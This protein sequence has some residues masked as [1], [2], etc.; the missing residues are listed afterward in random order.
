MLEHPDQINAMTRAIIREIVVAMGL[1]PE[2]VQSSL[3]LSL[4]RSTTEA[5]IDRAA[6]AFEKRVRTVPG[7]T[8]VNSDL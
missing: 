8:D 5:D 1:P 7:L 2:R 6:D 3:R 4:G